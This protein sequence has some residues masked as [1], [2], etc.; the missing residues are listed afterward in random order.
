MLSQT[1]YFQKLESNVQKVPKPAEAKRDDLI[2]PQ[3][4]NLN[5]FE[6]RKCWYSQNAAN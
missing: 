2:N 1:K 4:Y 6:H 5:K 3:I